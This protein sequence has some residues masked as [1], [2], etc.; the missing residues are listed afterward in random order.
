MKIDALAMMLK[1]GGGAVADLPTADIVS[2]TL[3]V[4]SMVFLLWK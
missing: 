2:S 3:Q 4:E 1:M